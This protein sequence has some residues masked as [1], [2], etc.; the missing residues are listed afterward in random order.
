V[1][2][3]CPSGQVVHRL[4]A[5]VAS[6]LIIVSAVAF[7]PGR[8]YADSG[9]EEQQFVARINAYRRA[10]G[11]VALVVDT[12]LANVARNWSEHNAESQQSSHNPDLAAEAGTSAKL[13]ENVGNGAGVDWLESSFEQS[14]EHRQNL[15]D[16]DFRF[17]GVGVVDTP[18][19]VWV[20]QD[21]AGEE[22]EAQPSQPSQPAQPAQ[23]SPPMQPSPPQAE[24]PAGW[25]T[26]M[27]PASA[28]AGAPAASPAPSVVV[29]ASTAPAVAAT[30]DDGNP[31]A[32]EM[33]RHALATWTA[34]TG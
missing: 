12:R 28:A 8:A 24:A 32:A 26:E 31:D 10:H 9:S 4:I 25:I 33:L 6:T 2:G 16:P 11:L 14:P 1:P 18:D 19:V 20:T 23:P 27:A 30:P 5:V 13:G 17:V 22:S 7:G 15:L 21:F 29:R 34:L 3:P